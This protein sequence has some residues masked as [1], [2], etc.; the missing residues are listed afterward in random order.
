M[1]ATTDAWSVLEFNELTKPLHRLPVA[2]MAVA[3][4]TICMVR[5]KVFA[6][7]TYPHSLGSFSRDAFR[8]TGNL[9][10]ADLFS[11]L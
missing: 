3:T 5:L 8:P 10:F 1:C 2:P 7:E 4:N 6:P 9:R 11:G